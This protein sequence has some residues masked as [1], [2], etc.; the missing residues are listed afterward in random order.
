MPATIRPEAADVDT[1]V[2]L[3]GSPGRNTRRL[4]ALIVVAVLAVPFMFAAD[5]VAVVVDGQPRSVS[6]YA[7]TVGQALDAAGI[8]IPFP[9]RDVHLFQAQ[10]AA[11]T[12]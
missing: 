6:T 10:A 11:S 12:N 3:V 7:Q 8:S 4:V 1:S 2:P 9:Q 5:R